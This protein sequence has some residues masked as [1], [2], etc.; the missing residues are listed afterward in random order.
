MSL[1]HCSCL[2]RV[3]IG[4]NISP[5]SIYQQCLVLSNSSYS[6][7]IQPCLIFSLFQDF[8]GGAFPQANQ[9]LSSFMPEALSYYS[10]V[11]SHALGMRYNAT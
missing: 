11:F 5:L 1:N 4:C 10:I 2:R 3:I 9:V 7:K 6:M 8:I